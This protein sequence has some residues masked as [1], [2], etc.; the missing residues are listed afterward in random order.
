MIDLY[1]FAYW[2]DGVDVH[3]PSTWPTERLAD[4]AEVLVRAAGEDANPLERAILSWAYAAVM[5][6]VEVRVDQPID[7]GVAEILGDG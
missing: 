2:P 1:E 3:D 6:K 4:V 7:E 5:R